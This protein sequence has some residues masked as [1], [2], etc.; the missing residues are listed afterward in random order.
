MPTTDESCS[1]L[2]PLPHVGSHLQVDGNAAK[3]S[4]NL[5]SRHGGPVVE[6]V[7]VECGMPHWD[8]FAPPTYI[9]RNSRLC[10][11]IGMLGVTVRYTLTHYPSLEALS[12]HSKGKSSFGISSGFLALRD[13]PRFKERASQDETSS[14]RPPFWQH[15]SI[16]R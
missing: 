15:F 10:C 11:A 14:R 6:C 4:R 1:I 12:L 7:G 9:S 3:T 2:S 5:M 16:S 8:C 13:K